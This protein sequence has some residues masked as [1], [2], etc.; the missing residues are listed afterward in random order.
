MRIEGD[1]AWVEVVRREVSDEAFNVQCSVA[2]F[3]GRN[4]EIWIDAN[5]RQRF[6]EGLRSVERDRRGEASLRAMSPEEFELVVRVVDLAGHVVIEG[7]VG[8][9]QF[10]A[11]LHRYDQLLVKFGFS[12]DPTLLPQVLRDAEQL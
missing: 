2:G 11:Y 10:S 1:N 6:V 12:F 7:F 5:E 4:G 9:L 8:K 3:A